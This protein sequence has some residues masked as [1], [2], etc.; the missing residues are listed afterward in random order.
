MMSDYAFFSKDS[1]CVGET[2][3]SLWGHMDICP[4]LNQFHVTSI[5]YL[6]LSSFTRLKAW[7]DV[8]KFC[9]DL[10][11]LLVSTEVR[12]A[13]D[14]IY[15]LSTIWVNPYQA[16][17]PNMEEVVTQLTALV[18]TGDDWPHTLVQL[19]W[20]TCHAPLPREGHLSTLVEGTSS[21]TCGRVSQLE[22]HQLL[23][24]NSQ[25]VYPAR[26]NGCE[27][28]LIASLPKLLAKG[29][30]LLGDEPVYLKVDIP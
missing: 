3:Q 8:E 6:E 23:S 29:T 17:V 27:V 24:S 25:V 15:G 11:Y 20:N 5:T 4:L 12:T 30:N 22:I 26:L 9:S 28:P 19:N 18:P 21:A 2:F 14:R 16:R 10:T 7:G 1:S 13:R